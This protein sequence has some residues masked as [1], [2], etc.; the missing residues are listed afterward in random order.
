VP[1]TDYFLEKKQENNL[2][3]THHRVAG[4]TMFKDVIYGEAWKAS[5][6]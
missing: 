3:V 4:N 1:F 6:V 5:H 2:Q